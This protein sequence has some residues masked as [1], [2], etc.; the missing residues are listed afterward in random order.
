MT[1]HPGYLGS[2]AELCADAC[3]Q[4]VGPALLTA[5]RL[6]R[7]S[8]AA[9]RFRTTRG[10][11]TAAVAQG[12]WPTLGA[13][14]LLG[15]CAPARA[16]G[17]GLSPAAGTLLA[18]LFGRHLAPEPY[19][20]GAFIPT[21]FL[22]AAE[23]EAADRLLAEVVAG[24]VIPVFAVQEQAGGEP[25]DLAETHIDRRGGSLRLTG[26]KRFIHGAGWATHFIVTSRLDGDLCT[27]IVARGTPGLRLADRL[28]ADGTL[29][30]E[31]VLDG[32]TLDSGSL[33]SEGPRCA[34]I[35]ARTLDWANVAVSA[36]LFGLS[37][38]LFG[39]TIDYLRIRTQF[40]RPIGAF[41]AL[42]HR[43]ADLYC[44]KEIARFT[45]AEAIRS[46]ADGGPTPAA[47]SRC[48]ARAAETAMQIGREAVQL[49]GA[50]G[51]SDEADVGLYLKRAMVLSAWF[52]GADHHRRRYAR[53][54]PYRLT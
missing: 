20:A 52:G 30:A 13:L 19:I 4:D 40:D 37:T 29:G 18:E 1:D 44:V 23:T 48:K 43:A 16:G 32:V 36:E 50:I 33:I 24:A 38:A 21:L 41:Q 15:A 35:L 9:R 8:D 46:L 28:M 54:N 26:R 25:W 14:G 31:L 12:V 10:S 22:A 42:Q 47:A 39:L 51:F 2:V 11:A 49:H 3:A 53:I 5:E 17:S 45:I 34:D 27:V 6:L 7:D